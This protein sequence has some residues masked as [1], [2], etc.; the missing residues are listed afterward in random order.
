MD[1][2]IVNFI[3]Y[4][5]FQLTGV[6]FAALGITGVCFIKAVKMFYFKIGPGIGGVPFDWW[7]YPFIP[8]FGYFIITLITALATVF[9]VQIC[10]ENILDALRSAE[11]INF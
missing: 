5:L 3:L 6:I 2:S 10:V 11:L 4:N 8:V 1:E 7:D 9:V